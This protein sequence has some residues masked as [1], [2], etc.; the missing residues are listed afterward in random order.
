MVR[1]TLDRDTI[2]KRINGIQ[3]E[4]GE[5]EKLSKIPFEEFKEGVGFKLAQFH[6]H[7]SLEGVFHISAH[8]L[9]RIPGGQVSEYKE[10]AMKLG[11]YG[12][13]DRDFANTTLK[14]MA[15]YRNRIVHFYAE[16]SPEEIYKI[17]NDNLGDFNIFLKGVK[18]VLE[19]PEKF[20]INS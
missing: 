15:G 7:R 13:V 5:L 11:E 12:I 2:L 17:I 10:M 19:N 3:N 20:G 1:L 16:I 18:N 14:N 9:S 4:F 8:I 6:L